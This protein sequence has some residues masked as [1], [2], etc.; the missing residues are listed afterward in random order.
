M[1]SSDLTTAEGSVL[2]CW[3]NGS[4]SQWLRAVHGGLHLAEK[5]VGFKSTSFYMVPEHL[6]LLV[7]GV[8]AWQDAKRRTSFL[9]PAHSVPPC[10]SRF[11]PAFAPVSVLPLCSGRSCFS[12]AGNP[13]PAQGVRASVSGLA[14]KNF[15]LSTRGQTT[16]G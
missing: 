1:R 3:E 6:H 10:G 4:P 12:A 15:L 2:D 11:H 9:S 5:V 16:V 7:D 13:A 8:F 14:W